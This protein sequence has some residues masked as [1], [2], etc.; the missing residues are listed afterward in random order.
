MLNGK[1]HRFTSSMSLLNAPA[2]ST[3]NDGL[4]HRSV[5][6]YNPRFGLRQVFFNQ[7]RGSDGPGNASSRI[8]HLDGIL[9]N[10]INRWVFALKS[11]SCCQAAKT[12]A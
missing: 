11:Q 1:K 2:N 3:A 10:A 5:T 7:I 9:K 12:G 4:R 6:Y 8:S